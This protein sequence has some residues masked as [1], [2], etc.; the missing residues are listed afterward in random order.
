MKLYQFKETTTLATSIESAWS[1][2]SNPHNLA[3]IT[4]PSL[5]FKVL[6]DPPADIYPGLIIHYT[7]SPL[8]GVPLQWVTEISHVIKNQ[9]FVDEQRYGPYA[10][11][12]HQHHFAETPDGV[13]MTDIVHYTLPLDPFSRMANSLVVRPQINAIFNFRKS[14]ML[15]L[16]PR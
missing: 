3:K 10:M 15:E 13:L 1:F 4:P 7:V 5:N 9:L 16:F 12:H 2:F 14:A 8:L 6:S 11:W